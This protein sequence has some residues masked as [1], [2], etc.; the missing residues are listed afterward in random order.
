MNQGSFRA[1]LCE[2]DTFEMNVNIISKG[3]NY[4]DV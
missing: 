1:V 3:H 4:T 2:S